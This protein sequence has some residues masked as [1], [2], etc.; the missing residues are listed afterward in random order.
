MI[1]NVGI[2]RTDDHAYYWNGEGPFT[3][4]T[5]ATKLYDKSDA[6]VGWAKKETAKFALRHLDTLVEHRLHNS[7]MPGCPPCMKAYRP[8]SGQE[9]ARKWVSSLPDYIRDAA[10]DLGTRVHAVAEDLANGKEEAI[11]A[12]LRPFAE[13]YQRFMYERDPDYLE[14]EYMGI[15]LTHGYAGT[16]D[17]MVRLDGVVTAVDIKTHT[18]DEPLPKTY[19]PDTAMQLAAC[20]RFEFIGKENDPTEYP[21]PQASAYAVLLLGR[22]GYRLIPYSVT[23]QTFEAFLHCL[24]LHGW[25]HGEAKTIVGSAA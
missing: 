24:A 9:A 20:A 21:V 18:K 5:T 23:Q 4:V 8:F 16:G 13:S 14:V 6:L 7:P 25:R 17:L 2:Y 10:A 1:P 3:S 11:E 15:N 12:E 22:D 19:Y